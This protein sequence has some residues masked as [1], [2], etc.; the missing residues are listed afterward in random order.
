MY[1][2]VCLWS[3]EDLLVLLSQVVEQGLT[4][5]SL[6]VPL[7][8]IVNLPPPPLHPLLQGPTSLLT[9][10]PSLCTCTEHSSCSHLSSALLA[11]ANVTLGMSSETLGPHLTCE[12]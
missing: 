11:R 12:G 9:L 4:H 2:C 10:C 7:S 5:V 1:L 8:S 3:L 6:Y